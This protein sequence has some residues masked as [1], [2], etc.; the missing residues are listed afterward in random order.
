MNTVGIYV[1]KG[2]SAVII[3]TLGDIVL[4]PLRDIPHTQFAINKLIELVQGLLLD[5]F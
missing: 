2:E 1:A 4:M 5:I 3:R